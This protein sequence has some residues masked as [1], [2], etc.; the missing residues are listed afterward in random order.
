MDKKYNVGKL[1]VFANAAEAL[2]YLRKRSVMI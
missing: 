2:Q 1:H